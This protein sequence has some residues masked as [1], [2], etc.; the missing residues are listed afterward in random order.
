M[1]FWTFYCS[2][3]D[4]YPLL[5]KIATGVVGTIIGDYVAQHLSHQAELRDARLRGQPAPGF[6]F[7]AVRTSR[8]VIYGALVGTPIG[9]AW[10]QLLDTQIMPE[11]MTSAQA[12]LTKMGMDQLLMC[13]LAT[14]LFFVV[15]RVWEGHPHDAFSYMRCKLGPTLKANYVL[16]P[17]AHIINFA[18]VPPAQRI[19]YCNAV[20][21]LWTV[22]LSSILNAKTPPAP[23]T[24]FATEASPSGPR[25][26]LGGNGGAPAPSGRGPSGGSVGG[27]KRA[28]QPAGPPDMAPGW[29]T[30]MVSG[31]GGGFDTDQDQPQ[32]LVARKAQPAG[33]SVAYKRLARMDVQPKDG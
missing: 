21:V 8:L 7:D 12:V 1:S 2:S 10:F 18:F 32:T 17:I 24:A 11:A 26:S 33:A 23:G 15:M 9:H 3:L 20:G 30:A 5:T 27:T 16:W 19:L 22:I 25:P 13:P 28:P 6:V 14:A 31:M 4:T 29:A